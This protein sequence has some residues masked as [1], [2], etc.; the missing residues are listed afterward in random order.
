MMKTKV[1]PKNIT[2]T[3]DGEKYRVLKDYPMLRA[4]C[5]MMGSYPYF[6]NQELAKA[7]ETNAPQESIYSRIQE[8][9]DCWWATMPIANKNAQIS[10][11]EIALNY[12][13][14]K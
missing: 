9:G 11:I 3:I 8:N 2:I 7:K 13:W 12:N 6:I 14:I 10:C 5:L 1:N 4:W